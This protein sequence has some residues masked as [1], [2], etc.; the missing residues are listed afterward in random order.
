MRRNNRRK[1]NNYKE[2]FLAIILC[3]TTI[4]TIIIYGKSQAVYSEDNNMNYSKIAVNWER[5]NEYSSIIDAGNY[6]YNYWSRSGNVYTLDKSQNQKGLLR[7][8]RLLKEDKR[9][10]VLNYATLVGNNGIL[11][12][13]ETKNV[14]DGK[15]KNPYFSQYLNQIAREGLSLNDYPDFATWK[16]QGTTNQNELWRVIRGKFNSSELDLKNPSKRVYIGV[17]NKGTQLILPVNDYV[18]VLVDGQVTKLNFSTETVKNSRISIKTKNFSGQEEI[19]KVNFTNMYYCK[20]WNNDPNYKCNNKKHYIESLHTDT[21][22]AHLD[23]FTTIDGDTRRI[24]DITPYLNPN[25]TEHKIELLCGDYCDGGGM[26]KLQVYCTEEPEIDVKKEGYIIK[27]N[28]E[29]PIKNDEGKGFSLD[30]TIYYKF[31]LTNTKDFDLVNAD[32]KFEDETLDIKIDSTGV[33]KDNKKVNDISGLSI[34]K[35]KIT[36]H[37][38]KALSLL[39]DLKAKETIS[40]KFNEVLYHKINNSDVE[41]G[42]YK[43]TVKGSIAYLN[44]ALRKEKEA[45]FK[46]NVIEGN[47]DDIS[48]K[49]FV[50][51]IKRDDTI[52]YKSDEDTE[53]PKLKVNDEVKFLIEVKN[54]GNNTI[55]NLSLSDNL[56]SGMYTQSTWKYY[57]ADKE[58]NPNDF[59]IMGNSTIKLIT[60]NWNTLEPNGS[61]RSNYNITNTA[62]IKRKDKQKESKIELEILRPE[63][64]I[65]KVLDRDNSSIE[66]DENKTFTVSIIGSDKKKYNCEIPLNKEYTVKDLDYGVKYTIKEMTQMHYDIFNDLSITMNKDTEKG[67]IKLVNKKNYSNRFFDSE[68]KVNTFVVR[69]KKEGT[70]YEK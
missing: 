34:S 11:T 25:I 29:T 64:K 46:V 15:S 63:L 4:F 1:R 52:I 54:N 49:K 12:N 8:G 28:I 41:Q 68:T 30:D 22:H 35:G 67:V 40:V 10:I 20:D 38:E 33:Y 27:D 47:F 58:F 7:T 62:I 24:G 43:N 3:I 6:S 59:S 57:N 60:S 53:I 66:E 44:G 55:G 16:F 32:I 51:S 61:E 39:K 70:N 23:N 31:L 19:Q 17:E 48:I 65:I 2:Y 26:T 69:L 21:W 14:W 36:E 18:I 50:Y 13:M 9:D 5:T 37:G 56:I 45:V 42:Y